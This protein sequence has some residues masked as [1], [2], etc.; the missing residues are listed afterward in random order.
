MGCGSNWTLPMMSCI[1]YHMQQM[2]YI[3]TGLYVVCMML[4]IEKITWRLTSAFVPDSWFL[5]SNK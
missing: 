2:E 5:V 4:K 1:L 3:C